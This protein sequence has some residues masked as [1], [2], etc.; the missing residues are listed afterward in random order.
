VKW[1]DSM[2]FLLDAG[3]VTEFQEI[4]PGS[5]LTKTDR[6]D[7]EEKG[8]LVRQWGLCAAMGQ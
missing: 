8:A 7:Q 5:V 1:L 2:L 4:G 6:S 3:V